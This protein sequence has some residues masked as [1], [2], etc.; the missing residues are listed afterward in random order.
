VQVACLALTVNALDWGYYGICASTA[1]NFLARYLLTVYLVRFD[2][3]VPLPEGAED[4]HF[5]SRE[6]ITDLRHQIA[7]NS[8][9]VS[10]NLPGRWALHILTLMA[11]YLG[12]AAVAT[13]A[14]MNS[15]SN[16]A[17]MVP[18]GFA[19]TC[20]TL[21]G[22]AV[23]ALHEAQ[24]KSYYHILISIN[25]TICGTTML[26]LALFRDQVIDSFT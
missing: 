25:A 3:C 13:Q 8:K 2:K 12:P 9:Q 4:V 11:S 22:N 19:K 26:G 21:V 23:G 24:A 15:V 18:I 17:R 7:L 20:G 6:T 16:L 5:F 10:M 14:V 1:A